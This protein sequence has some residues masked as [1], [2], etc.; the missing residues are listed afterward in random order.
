MSE[1]NGYTGEVVQ[2]M[3]LEIE[4]RFMLWKVVGAWVWILGR[5]TQQTMAIS[6]SCFFL[7]WI[8]VS[9]QGGS[10]AVQGKGEESRFSTPANLILGPS[11]AGSWYVNLG[12]YK[13][14]LGIC[15]TDLVHVSTSSK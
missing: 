1:N 14:Y 4:R 7:H 10:Q 12:K 8:I 13:L 6:S 5:K 2:R 11:C 3:T 15:K 9:E